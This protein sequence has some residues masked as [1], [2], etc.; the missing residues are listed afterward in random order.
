M[1]AKVHHGTSRDP[2]FT[3]LT[4]LLTDDGWGDTFLG[5]V[6]KWWK[7]SVRKWYEQSKNQSL[8]K[9][10]LFLHR[11]S[12]L[13]PLDMSADRFIGGLWDESKSTS[14]QEMNMLIG[15]CIYEILKHQNKALHVK[16][17]PKHW[18]YQQLCRL[19]NLPQELQDFLKR[20]HHINSFAN[21]IK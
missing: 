12:L 4:A 15:T 1:N 3:V 16:Q 5:R 19:H 10:D 9:C 2:N 13:S 20:P 11:R 17:Q 21:Q 14:V 6:L 7:N 8:N 18:C